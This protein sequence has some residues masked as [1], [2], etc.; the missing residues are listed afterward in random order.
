MAVWR[1]QDVLGASL[2]FWP[3]AATVFFSVFVSLFVGIVLIG[4]ALV[5][6]LLFCYGAYAALR[7]TGCLEALLVLLEKLRTTI[8][9][10][11]KGHIEKSFVLEGMEQ[12]AESKEARLYVCQPHG[13]YGF[14]W[15]LHFCTNSTN[16]IASVPKPKVAIHSVF[17]H[18]PFVRELMASYG[19]IAA[20]ETVICEELEKG[21]SVALLIGGIEELYLT[22]SKTLTLVIEKRKGYARIAKK[23]NVPIQP[24][25]T[26]GENELFPMSDSK[27]WKRLQ[28]ILYDWLHVALP[29]PTWVSF[30]RW[31]TIVKGPL[32]E[33]CTSVFLKPIVNTKE[34]SEEAIRKEYLETIMKVG[35]ERNLHLDIAA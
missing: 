25:L 21:N 12:I 16:W 33:P 1:W 18:I 35:S 34:K 4:G 6:F 7:D 20:T 14:S 27:L 24:I 15:Y 13:L 5:C 23:C 3:I 17:F 31:L 2:L 22:N 32:E 8:H 28:A 9:T 11:L 19:C 29:L 26:V 30:K 10:K